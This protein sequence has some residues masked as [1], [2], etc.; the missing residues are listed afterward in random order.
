[1]DPNYRAQLLQ[2]YDILEKK[3]GGTGASE[4][5]AKLIVAALK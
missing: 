3:L 4:K 1:L 2:K 5:T